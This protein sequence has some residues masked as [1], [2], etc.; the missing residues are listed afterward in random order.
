MSSSRI[1]H[2]LGNP[3]KSAGIGDTMIL[4]ERFRCFRLLRWAKG[5]DNLD[6]KF[7]DKSRFSKFVR[8]A[9]VLR[10]SSLNSF[11]ERFR[12]FIWLTFL[13]ALSLMSTISEPERFNSSDGSPFTWILFMICGTSY[14]TIYPLS[15][16]LAITW[17]IGNKSKMAA[18][19][20]L[21]IRIWNFQPE[22]EYNACVNWVLQSFLEYCAG[23]PYRRL[24]IIKTYQKNSWNNSH[25]LKV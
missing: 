12:D 8:P 4:L 14:W 25:F 10:R 7:L 17:I 5:T 23:I 19:N 6:I 3:K 16:P 21:L 20:V 9:N 15:I 1:T 11:L 13:N 24:F 22:K 18:R 2:D